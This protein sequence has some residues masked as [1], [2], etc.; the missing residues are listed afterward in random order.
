MSSE[1]ADYIGDILGRAKVGWS[2]SDPDDIAAIQYQ[3]WIA[4]TNFNG[5]ENYIN[6]MRTGYPDTPMATTANHPNKP[7]RLLYPASEYSS[8]SANVPNISLGEVFDVNGS[9]PFIY[10]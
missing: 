3:R 1:G 8:N 4:L 5:I 6:Y 9:T 7:Y 2:G 10:K